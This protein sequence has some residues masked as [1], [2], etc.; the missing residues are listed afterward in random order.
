M[1][2][3]AEP[4]IHIGFHKTG[5][6]WLQRR[7]FNDQ[8]RFT[9]VWPRTII[10]TA[11]V[12]GDPFT[13]DPKIAGLHFQPFLDA[14]EENGT[15][16]VISHERLCGQPLLSGYDS[17]QIADRL[18]ATFPRAKVLIVIREQRSM[19]TSVYKQHIR[20]SGTERV[21]KLWRSYTAR[22]HRRPRPTLDFFEY[23]NIIRYYQDHFGRD[24]VLVLP[25][26]LFQ[27]DALQFAN[28]VS[29]FVG[30]PP[31]SDV[32]IDRENVAVPAILLGPLRLSNIA[33]RTLGLDGLIGGP[34]PESP[35]GRV[36][37]R[38][39]KYIGPTIPKSIARP[40]EKRLQTAIAE[41]ARGRFAESNQITAG[42]TGLDLGALGYEMESGPVAP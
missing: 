8:G 32:A 6:T 9:L 2:S 42:I 23:H 17:A 18:Q 22:E 13:F 30:V 14:A 36:R 3:L 19:M 26:E 25:F 29:S 41:L 31:V 33:I 37:L 11:F 16:T 20:T 39:I 4:L 40:F 5:T 10:D 7:F 21:A 24:R 35:A 34:I 15:L 27:R 12:G 28:E 38:I 1:G